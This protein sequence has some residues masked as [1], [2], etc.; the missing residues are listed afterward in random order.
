MS[1]SGSYDGVV[2]YQQYTNGCHIS[3]ASLNLFLF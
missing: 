3:F 2:I 1:Y